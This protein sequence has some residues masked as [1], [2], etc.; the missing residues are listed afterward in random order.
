[1]DPTYKV[2]AK[3]GLDEALRAA[4][5]DRERRE[6]AEASLAPTTAACAQLEEEK[7]VL[8]TKLAE[9]EGE[10]AEMQVQYTTS[11]TIHSLNTHY[12][13]TT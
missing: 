2:L 11:T 4:K 7:V 13:L 1:L 6:Q 12:T 10:G 3:E 8:A 5:E 9:R